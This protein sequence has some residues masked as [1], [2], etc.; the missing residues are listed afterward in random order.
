MSVFQPLF[1]SFLTVGSWMIFSLLMN[2]EFF[3]CKIVREYNTGLTEP[4][5]AKCVMSWLLDERESPESRHENKDQMGARLT[6]K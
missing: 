6:V 5:P 4:L 3:I 2:L 1:H